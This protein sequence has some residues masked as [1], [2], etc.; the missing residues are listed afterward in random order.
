MPQSSIKPFG[1]LG[2]PTHT[3]TSK[4][5]MRIKNGISVMVYEAIQE[6][7]AEKDRANKFISEFE[8][9]RMMEN[10]ARIDGASESEARI[11]GLWKQHQKVGIGFFIRFQ[12]PHD[13]I[14]HTM[15]IRR[16]W[17]ER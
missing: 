5:V 7:F 17:T 14:W 10:M 16:D 9:M 2:F 1:V 3:N 4:L 11:Y 13:P 12:V 8:F 6:G 15:V